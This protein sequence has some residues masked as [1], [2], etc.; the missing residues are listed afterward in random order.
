MLSAIRDI[1]EL[2]IQKACEVEEQIR[3]KILSINLDTDKSS[4]SAI[5]IEDFDSERHKKNWYLFKQGASKGNVP[6]PFCPLTEPVKTY[7]KIEGWLNQCNDINENTLK[8]D[9]SRYLINKALE[10]LTVKREAIITDIAQKAKDIPKKESKFLTVKLD[11]KYLGEYEVFKKCLVTFDEKK[12]KRSANSGVCSICSMP[13][14]EVSGKTDVFRFYTIDKPGFITG[15][16][17]EPHA[18]KNFP[19]CMECRT[20]LENGRK[21][22]EGNLK[23]KFYGLNYLLIPRLL[24]GGQSLLEEVLDILSDTTK[25]VALKERIKN[26]ITND[27]DEILEYLSE[28]KDVLTLNFLFLQRQQSAERI[29]L[30]IEDVF[31]SRIR[32]IFESK[33]NVDHIFNNGS[34]K[35]FTFGTIREFFSRS[36]DNKKQSDLNKYFL[37]IVDSVFK[38]SRLD[39]SFLLRFYMVV[40]R[41]EFINEGYFS[42]RIKDALMNT[43]FFEYL[44]LINFEEVRNM[45]EGLFSSVF[46]QYGKSFGSSAKK[47]VFLMGALTQM[48]LNKQWI[49][50][51]ARP[52][53]KKLKGLKMDEKD[54]KALLPEVQNKLEEYDAFDKGKR[55]TASE[56]AKYLLDAGDGWKMPVDEINFYFACGMNLVDSIADIVYPKN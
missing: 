15:G 24:T 32:K 45:E 51:N 8:D 19:V 17:Q 3:G 38:G 9:S 56:T 7:K 34:D 14:K 22:L 47:G 12:R 4:Y 20:F 54:I 50:R 25:T 40:V 26:R 1:G 35:G 53:M 37:E 2:V 46:A 33:D 27:D 44:G 11:G 28:E 42:F 39:F 31:P 13:D 52:F 41:K 48:L 29:L 23:F 49:E 18:W 55:L 6:S 10:V 21:F 36:D 5:D 16:F 43:V 30:L